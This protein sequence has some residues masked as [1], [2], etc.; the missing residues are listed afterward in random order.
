MRCK[1]EGGVKILL[2]YMS[3]GLYRDQE[4]EELIGEHRRGGGHYK[5]GPH[6]FACRML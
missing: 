5:G 4:S 6:E 2:E 1:W 3:L